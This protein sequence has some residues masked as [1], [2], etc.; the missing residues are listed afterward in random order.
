MASAH[1]DSGTIYYVVCMGIMTTC[2]TSFLFLCQ[3]CCGVICANIGSVFFQLLAERL[4]LYEEDFKETTNLNAIPRIFDQLGL[5]TRR[6][7]WMHEANAQTG[8]GQQWGWLRLPTKSYWLKFLS[9]CSVTHYVYIPHHLTDVC[10]VGP[11]KFFQTL[12]NMSNAS[13]TAELSEEQLE[14]LRRE[15]GIGDAWTQ[16]DMICTLWE[17]RILCSCMLVVCYILVVPHQ[18]LIITSVLLFLCMLLA[19]GSRILLWCPRAASHLRAA[20][21]DIEH[22][23]VSDD[24]AYQLMEDP[25]DLP[26]LAAERDHLEWISAERHHLERHAVGIG[27]SGD[28]HPTV[29]AEDLV[30]AEQIYSVVGLP[31]MHWY[32]VLTQRAVAPLPDEMIV[33]FKAVAQM[34][35]VPLRPDFMH[36]LAQRTL[37]PNGA[38]LQ[39]VCHNPMTEPHLTQIYANFQKGVKRDNFLIV[40]LPPLPLFNL[41][42]TSHETP[43]ARTAKSAQFIGTV[44]DFQT[45]LLQMT[46]L[47]HKLVFIFPVEDTGQQ[48]PTILNRWAFDW[49]ARAHHSESER[50]I[51]IASKHVLGEDNCHWL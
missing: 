40:I 44:G 2:V 24:R 16:A 31:K 9:V 11:T 20:S 15:L 42:L 18:I 21:H 22:G 19:I 6:R 46:A 8:D 43:R 1:D 26:M 12:I 51:W 39:M 5:R 7:V 49:P 41:G 29:E 45:L 10:G 14:S 37:I 27:S 13:T 25:D 35:A 17:R 28:V 4:D 32:E 38:A 30:A 3:K 36:Y 23:L 47:M 50:D 34:Y 48:E 33:E